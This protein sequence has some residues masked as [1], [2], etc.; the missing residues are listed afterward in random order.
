[1]HLYHQ[2]Q[3]FSQ[4]DYLS[5]GPQYILPKPMDPRLK[6]RVSAAAARAA[7]KSGVAQLPLP[8]TYEVNLE[9]AF[10]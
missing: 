6:M 4:L 2:L 1:M 8:A 5:F 7:I 3:I 10:A 9:S